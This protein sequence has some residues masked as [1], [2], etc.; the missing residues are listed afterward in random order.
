MAQTWTL[1]AFARILEQRL[2][3]LMR[4]QIRLQ[5]LPPA[6]SAWFYA[7]EA[8]GRAERQPEIDQLEREVQRLHYLA[9]YSQSERREQLLA[10]LDH[11]LATANEATWDRLEHDLAVMAGRQL[12]I[13]SI[14]TGPAP[15]GNGV[16]SDHSTGR[17]AA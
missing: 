16:T 3:E 8:Y 11:G 2:D 10:R 12:H 5:D 14:R 6:V 9:F 17:K 13:D 4:G 15:D 1:E 7:G